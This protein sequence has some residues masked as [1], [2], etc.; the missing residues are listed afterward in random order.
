MIRA[1]FV[2]AL[3]LLA[4]SVQAQTRV[5]AGGN[6]QAALDAAL[7]GDIL[8]L[9]AGATFTGNYALPVK[10]GTAPITVRTRGLT[11]PETRI[12]AAANL[13]TLR[14][15]NSTPALRTVGNTAH[16]RFDGIRFAAGASQ[17]DIV[18]L[19]DAV[20]AD[21]AQLPRDL[22]FDRSI[23][24]ADTSAKNALSLNSANTSIRRSRFTG[25]KLAGIESHAIICTNGPGPFTIEDNYIEAGSIGVMFGGAKP[26]VP[27]LV[28][29]DI[30]FQRNTV[31]RPLAM[32][33]QIGWGI[34][35]IFEL[36]NA[37]RVTV[38]GNIFE[39]NWPDAQSGW[40]ITITV[41]ANSATAPW[42]TIQHVLF[43]DNIVR[44]ASAGFNILGLDN[45][46]SSPGGPVYPSTPMDDVVIRNNLVYDLDR[47]VWTGPRPENVGNGVFMQIDGGPR[48]LHVENNTG[49]GNG[50]MLNLSGPPIPG[51]VFRRNIVQKVRSIN[52]ATGGLVDSYGIYGNAVGEG[53][54]AVSTYFPHVDGFP[55]VVLTGNVLAGATASQYTLV[56]GNVFPSVAALMADFVDPASGNYRLVPTSSLRALSTGRAGA[57]QDAIEAALARPT[58]SVVTNVRIIP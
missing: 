36:K 8:E 50:N 52:P 37:R 51:F 9:D 3:S 12:D 35:N 49:L 42:T 48:N 34:K 56:P 17:G 32:R 21:V 1:T 19:G 39:H 45:Q 10:N 47:W 16:W 25:I 6:L 2:L 57:D 29:S 31:T 38:R 4:S 22:V 30:L 54:P 24:Q 41:R 18:A 55:D 23:F 7:P 26:A 11:L 58:V 15:A 43:E 5:P 46:V 40:T 53:N 44:H 27:N 13:A 28:P 20:T 33:S 14:T